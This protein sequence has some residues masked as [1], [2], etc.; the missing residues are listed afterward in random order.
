MRLI[1]FTAFLL[2]R[3]YYNSKSRDIAYLR[4][5]YTLVFLSCFHIAQILLI[6]NKFSSIPIT[7]NDSTFARLF[8]IGL[9]IIPL[10][11]FYMLIIKES[12]LKKLNFNESKIRIGYKHLI[13]Y[14]IVTFSFTFLLAIIRNKH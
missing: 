5:L 7:D 14:S 8:K 9:F 1:K 13:A 12:E 11:V 10:F 6:F 4:M 3:Y 2:Y